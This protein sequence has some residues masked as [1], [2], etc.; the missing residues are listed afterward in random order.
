MLRHPVCC[1]M[2]PQ[3]DASC[4]MSNVRIVRGREL[5]LLLV[6]CHQIKGEKCA[7]LKHCDLDS[8]VLCTLPTYKL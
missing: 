3:V 8:I 7:L 6:G 4:H 5:R 2:V 1:V